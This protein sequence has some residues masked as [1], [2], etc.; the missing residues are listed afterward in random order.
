M[1]NNPQSGKRIGLH[2]GGLVMGVAY[3]IYI[4]S[5]DDT[6][7]EV[8]PL[9]GDLMTVIDLGEPLSELG[10]KANDI[11][12]FDEVTLKSADDPQASGI[13]PFK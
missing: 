13:K 10:L 5:I 2:E 11:V 12:S 1:S 9:N 8:L 4:K 7:A 3:G 6:H